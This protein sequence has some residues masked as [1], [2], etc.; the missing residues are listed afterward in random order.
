MSARPAS[1][2]A[3]VRHQ[4]RET[5]AGAPVALLLAAGVREAL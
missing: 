3:L 5:P 2:P 1:A 4:R